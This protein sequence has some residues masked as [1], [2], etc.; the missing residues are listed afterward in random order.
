MPSQ[1]SHI[2]KRWA[3]QEPEPDSYTIFVEDA[4]KYKESHWI[5][6]SQVP[7]LNY[8]LRLIISQWQKFGFCSLMMKSP[9]GILHT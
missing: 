2:L 4:Y 3:V 6:Y 5:Y 9:S 1:T 8:I 7:S